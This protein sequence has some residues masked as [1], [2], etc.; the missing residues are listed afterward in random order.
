QERA[1]RWRVFLSSVL[2]KKK[3]RPRTTIPYYRTRTARQSPSHLE[4]WNQ[5]NVITTGWRKSGNFRLGK[6]IQSGMIPAH[7]S[8]RE[9]SLDHRF[10]EK[11]PL[12][13]TG[14]YG[15]SSAR[16]GLTCRHINDF[17]E[18]EVSGSP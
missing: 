8:K 18:I 1:L 17:M 15:A 13:G 3:G 9:T 12:K 5:L 14:C 4:A 2:R 6:R 7:L 10:S 16:I 11:L